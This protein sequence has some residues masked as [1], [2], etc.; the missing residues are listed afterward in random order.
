M[1][2]SIGTKMDTNKVT[3]IKQLNFCD[4]FLLRIYLPMH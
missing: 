1:T 3:N 2:K 4:I